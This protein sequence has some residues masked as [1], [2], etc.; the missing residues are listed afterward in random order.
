[1]YHLI[2]EPWQLASGHAKLATGHVIKTDLTLFKSGDKTESLFKVFDSF[3]SARTY[4]TQVISNN[5]E[6]ECWIINSHHQTV[7][8]ADKN[9]ERRFT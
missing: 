9:G 6:I 1:M 8:C 4:T 7:Y 5:H 2:L 3:E